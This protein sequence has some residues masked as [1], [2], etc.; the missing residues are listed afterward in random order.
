MHMIRRE[1]SSSKKPIVRCR[2][3]FVCRCTVVERVTANTLSIEMQQTESDRA[4]HHS[5]ISDQT[6]DKNHWNVVITP[7]VIREMKSA[8]STLLHL[9][10]LEFMIHPHV[11]ITLTRRGACFPVATS[12][13]DR[14]KVPEL[15]ISKGQCTLH[16]SQPRGHGQIKC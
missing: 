7:V 10:N 11:S 1:A 5:K 8:T 13:Q 3:H 15:E 12:R 16:V 14:T 9:H 6:Y 4:A 2:S